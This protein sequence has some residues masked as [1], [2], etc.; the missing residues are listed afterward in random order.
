VDDVPEGRAA[1]GG[2]IR[3]T[4]SFDTS[5]IGLRVTAQMNTVHPTSEMGS[6]S[7][8]S[9][10]PREGFRM[11]KFHR[12]GLLVGRV[13]EGEWVLVVGIT[14]MGCI[15]DLVDA[16]LGGKVE[17]WTWLVWREGVESGARE[18]ERARLSGEQQ[19]GVSAVD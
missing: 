11:R 10:E 2:I 6:D 4:R 1:C 12:L 5:R 8:H 15:V 3:R 18:N 14:H 9:L 7:G 19:Y 17:R 13:G 16:H